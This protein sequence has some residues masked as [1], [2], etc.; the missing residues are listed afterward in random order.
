MKSALPIKAPKKD[1][2][3]HSCR[4]SLGF[5]HF[6]TQCTDEKGPRKRQHSS[7]LRGQGRPFP[8]GLFVIIGGDRGVSV[9]DP[10]FYY[11]YTRTEGACPS[12]DSAVPRLRASLETRAVSSRR[13]KFTSA[14]PQDA[15]GG[16]LSSVAARSRRRSPVKRRRTVFSRPSLFSLLPPPK[17]A[18]VPDVCVMLILVHGVLISFSLLIYS[19]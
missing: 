17:S 12:R 16:S 15:P 18:P 7:Q 1:K 5:S 8:A 13:K 11:I 2:I 9:I 6:F 19:N 10:L 3:V 4:G 14:V